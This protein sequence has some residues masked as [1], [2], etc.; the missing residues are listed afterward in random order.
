MQ[1][2]FGDHNCAQNPPFLSSSWKALKRRCMVALIVIAL[3]T[4]ASAHAQTNSRARS[5]AQQGVKIAPSYQ[6]TSDA[7]HSE[8]LAIAMAQFPLQMTRGGTQMLDQKSKEPVAVAVAREHI[9]AW[10]NHDFEKARKSLATDVHVT[11]STTL[12]IMAPTDVTGVDD[13]MKGLKKFAQAVVPGSARIIA[14]EGDDRNALVFVVVTAQFGPGAPKMKLPAAR[15]YLLD[16]SGKIKTEQV[17]FYAVP[18]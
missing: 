14:S 11:A 1:K 13:Y 18:E 3:A 8:G 10:S 2:V 6:R 16:D 9:E 7:W 5:D 12:P 17:I 15:L 4:L